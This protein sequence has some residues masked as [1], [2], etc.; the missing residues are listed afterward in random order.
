MDNMYIA[1]LDTVELCLT[2]K[3]NV[4]CNNCSSLCAQAPLGREGDLTPD[5]V[6][7]FLMD[8]I[9]N[10]YKWKLITLH[11]GEPVLNPYIYD[12]C[13]I[14]SNYCKQN[15]IGIWILTNFSTQDI[16]DR[17]KKIYT[18]FKIGAGISYKTTS[19]P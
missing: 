15:D 17:V 7:K 1:K 3:C 18:D 5:N 11:G 8:S 19:S 16:R 4:N 9:E 14:I 6:N 2:Y 13:D 12:I 10:N